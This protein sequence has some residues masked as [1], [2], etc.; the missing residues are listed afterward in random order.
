MN[1]P[2][3]PLTQ[4]RFEG[5]TITQ[6]TLTTGRR[7]RG[8]GGG[9]GGAKLLMYECSGGINKLTN[10][11]STVLSMIVT[12]ARRRQRRQLATPKWENKDLLDSRM[13]SSFSN[14]QR[15]RTREP[16]SFFDN[17]VVAKTSPQDVGDLVLLELRN[18]LA[19]IT[20]KQM[21]LAS[22]DI[23]FL[24]TSLKTWRQISYSY[25]Y[26]F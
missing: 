1:P 17:G 25:S 26:S 19:I 3:L 24:S 6:P 20:Q 10:R 15:V 23:T 18:S 16:V 9:G 7:R 2:P 13:S 11:F 14:R 12:G 8:E 4:C 21:S 5:W 22:W